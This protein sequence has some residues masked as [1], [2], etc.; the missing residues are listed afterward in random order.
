MNWG[1]VLTAIALAGLLAVIDAVDR[2]FALLAVAALLFAYL[3]RRAGLRR[4]VVAGVVAFHV[5][6]LLLI[7]TFSAPLA[8]FACFASGACAYAILA[9]RRR[10]PRLIALA[11]AHLLLIV[12]C[13]QSP[14]L[15]VGCVI[16]LA[17]IS[18]L[19]YTFGG[20]DGGELT[21]PQTTQ[22]SLAVP[23]AGAAQSGAGSAQVEVPWSEPD[24]DP[25]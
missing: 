17:M 11:L 20:G 10:G 21:E 4:R 19:F 24:D 18:G 13:S 5:A 25:R 6:L 2:A 12:V 15:A 8:G 1:R 9:V 22:A 14:P 7:A 23:A 16:G 3:L